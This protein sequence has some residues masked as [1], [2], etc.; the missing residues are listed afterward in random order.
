ML[1]DFL[2]QVSADDYTLEGGRR[3]AGK[4]RADDEDLEPKTYDYHLGAD[5]GEVDA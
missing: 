2:R 1:A 3:R 5:F 4:W